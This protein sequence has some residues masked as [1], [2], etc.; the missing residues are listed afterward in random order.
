MSIIHQ[1]YQNM[2]NKIFKDVINTEFHDISFTNYVDLVMNFNNEIFR[3]ARLTLK[4]YFESI[5]EYYKNSDERKRKYYTKG[6]Y[7]RYLVTIFGEI[8][9]EREY[10]VPI[11]STEDD[12]FFFID[13]FLGLKPGDTYDP[14]VKALLMEAKAS[15]SF[16]KAAD[17]VSKLISTRNDRTIHISRQTVFNIFKSFDISDDFYSFFDS[18]IDSETLYVILDE[19]YISSQD[20]DH[21]SIMVKHAVIYSGKTKIGKNRNKLDGK[22]VIS[23]ID[24]VETFANK[25][26]TIIDNNYANIKNIIIAGDGANWIY[27][28][29]R[30]ITSI[31][32]VNKT[33]VLD[34][35][36]C[37][38]AINNITKDD[39]YKALL[40]DYLFHDKKA[41]F[42][43]ICNSIIDS[44]PERID[45][46]NDKLSYILNNWGSI[47]HMKNPLFIGCPMES[48]IAN[49][50]AKPFARDPKAYKRKNLRK[51]IKL[52]DYQLN[53]I[54]I[55]NLYLHKDKNICITDTLY[56]SDFNHSTNIPALYSNHT[57]TRNNLHDLCYK[58]N[59]ITTL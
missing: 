35:F 38:Q 39:D 29:Y 10:Y 14:I 34:K 40:Y 53:E 48:H 59:N 37:C 45:T 12:G 6:K 52:R 41:D 47:Q 18:P 44:N 21:E 55:F 46:I 49:D 51:H 4:K 31:E 2:L 33:F 9:F 24:G 26:N 32:K 54:N 8:Y 30:D 13:K 43:T 36:H 50:L 28:C 19:K 15:Q 1:N 23:S 7:S 5:D 25:I 17:D 42:I 20:K 11:Y 57:N 56:E 27:S 16:Q 3:C 58:L 22:L